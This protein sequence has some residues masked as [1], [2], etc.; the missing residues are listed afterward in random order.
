MILGLGKTSISIDFALL[1]TPGDQLSSMH[2]LWT[3]IASGWLVLPPLSH[4]PYA[5]YSRMVQLPYMLWCPFSQSSTC[6]T[7]Q[8]L[9]SSLCAS[10]SPTWYLSSTMTMSIRGSENVTIKS[11]S[12]VHEYGH[13]SMLSVLLWIRQV[14]GLTK[15]EPAS[16]IVYSTLRK[17]ASRHGGRTISKENSRR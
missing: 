13:R 9:E 16:S 4:L 15:D 11:L 3:L 12:A 7:L 5:R 1:L 2:P 17:I 14:N 6:R 10:I 8:S